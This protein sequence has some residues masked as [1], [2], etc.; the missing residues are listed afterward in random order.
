MHRAPERFC[1]DFPA[2]GTSL[3]MESGLKIFGIRCTRFLEVVEF[4]YFRIV[5]TA[6]LRFYSNC[7]TLYGLARL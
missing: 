4:Q 3:K 6:R 2:P 5:I 1:F 7:I